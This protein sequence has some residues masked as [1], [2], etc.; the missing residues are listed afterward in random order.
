MYDVVLLGCDQESVSSRVFWLFSKHSHCVPNF[1]DFL[2]GN[3][4]RMTNFAP[5]K[6]SI[7]Q[8]SIVKI[9]ILSC[10]SIASSV[11]L[12][13]RQ[14]PTSSELSVNLKNSLC[15]TSLRNGF[16]FWGNLPKFLLKFLAGLIHYCIGILVEYITEDQVD[17]KTLQLFVVLLQ[18]F[19]PLCVIHLYCD[20]V[21][22]SNRS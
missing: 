18:A 14:C 19:K 16:S 8:L 6:L 15:K 4:R 20:P 22:M 7:S 21:R 3:S 1:N 2:I 11:N 10:E 5:V 12:I 13:C 9:E 17:A